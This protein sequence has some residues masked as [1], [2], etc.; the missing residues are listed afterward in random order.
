MIDRFVVGGFYRVH[1]GKGSDDNL[2]APGMA[3]APMALTEAEETPEHVPTRARRYAYR[4]V[5]RLAALAAGRE[6]Q[7]VQD[8][9]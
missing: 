3:F 8:K 6:I 1:S 4:I 9:V 5:A 2:N 7:D